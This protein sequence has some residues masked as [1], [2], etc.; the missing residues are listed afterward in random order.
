MWAG[1]NGLG[2]SI[3]KYGRAWA[4]FE[5]HISGRAGLGQAYLMLIPCLSPAQIGLTRPTSRFIVLLLIIL[6]LLKK[7]TNF[8]LNLKPN[9]VFL[10]S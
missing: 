1:L 10:L 5:A 7:K 2:L 4:K 6:V 3:Y 8:N 9:Y